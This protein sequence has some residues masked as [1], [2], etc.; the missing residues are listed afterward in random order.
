MLFGIGLD[1]VRADHVHILNEEDTTHHW[2]LLHL[3]RW[4]AL[5]L[6][7]GILDSRLP[8]FVDERVGELDEVLIHYAIPAKMEIRRREPVKVGTTTDPMIDL[9]LV[10]KEVVNAL[11]SLQR[12]DTTGLQLL[13]GVDW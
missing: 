10:T 4:R 7:L 6:L 2:V 13:E 12:E 8:R 3:I 9:H 1:D 11:P 5:A